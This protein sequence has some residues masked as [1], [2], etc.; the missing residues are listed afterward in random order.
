MDGEKRKE[1][2]REETSNLTDNQTPLLPPTPTSKA[3]YTPKPLSALRLSFT[4][5]TSGTSTGL[6]YPAP[7]SADST[8]LTALQK[9][10]C[11]RVWSSRK[12]WHKW[13]SL[14]TPE[15]RT[16]DIDMIYKKE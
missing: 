2:E 5:L 14:K 9:Q 15:E 1:N 3:S 16:T 10:G 4:R 12:G 13:Q 8:S 11:E 6:L 7:A